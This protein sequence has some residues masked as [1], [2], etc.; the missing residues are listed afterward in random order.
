[1]TV[2]AALV[3]ACGGSGGSATGAGLPSDVERVFPDLSFARITDIQSQP[4][5]AGND[6]LFVVEQG[7]TI[8]YFY[9]DVF[10]P[11]AQTYLD[12]GDILEFSDNG[13]EGLLGL[14]FDPDFDSNGFFYVHLVKRSPRRVAILRFHDDGTRPVNTATEVT[15]LEA[16]EFNSLSAFTNHV[17]GGMAF[18]P[19]DGY[20]YLTMGDGGSSFDPDG[21]AQDRSDLRGSILRI[22]VDG[23][24]DTSSAT[25]Y[26]IPDDNPYFNAMG[27]REEILAHGLRNPFRISIEQVDAMTQRVWVG[28][29][30]QNLLEEIDLIVAGAN[31]GWDCREG[32]SDVSDANDSAACTTLVDSDFTPPVHEYDRSQGRSVTGGYVYSGQRL[33]G[34]LSGRYV[35]G[36]FI[37]GRIWALDPDTGENVLLVDSTL[38]ISTFGTG[39]EGDLYIG[40]YNGALYRLVP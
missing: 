9:P 13:E 20:L 26:D 25:N 6:R 40:D 33:A 5:A 8:R 19:V 38:N 12:V 1:M 4:D 22:D 28:D 23:T 37:S 2:V 11:V 7:G 31:Y 24:T 10:A 35:Y 16:D 3:V 36:D 29:V 34:A 17:A 32:T 21:A 15:V 30:G 39:V 14:A 18:G 27:F